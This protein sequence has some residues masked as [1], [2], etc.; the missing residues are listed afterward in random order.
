MNGAEALQRRGG[1]RDAGR[2]T[3]VLLPF[4]LTNTP[5]ENTREK[6]MYTEWNTWRLL[7]LYEYN[8]M[9]HCNSHRLTMHCSTNSQENEG[10]QKSHCNRCY[11][12]EGENHRDDDQGECDNQWKLQEHVKVEG[13]HS[14]HFFLIF[15]EAVENTARRRGVKETH[16]AAYN[17]RWC[18]STFFTNYKLWSDVV[19]VCRKLFGGSTLTI[20]FWTWSCGVCM[21]RS[22]SQQWRRRRWWQPEPQCLTSTVHRRAGKNVGFH[23]PWCSRCSWPLVAKTETWWSGTHT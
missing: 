6:S 21:Q 20:P 22:R 16:G 11:Q 2:A 8:F 13:K 17:L 23:S 15:G 19:M 9:K 18:A 7:S 12:Q 5:L 14:V 3:D 10:E 1:K 4:Q